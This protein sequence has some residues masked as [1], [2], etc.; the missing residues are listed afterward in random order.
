M[1]VCMCVRAEVLFCFRSRHTHARKITSGR[2]PSSYFRAYVLNYAHMLVGCWQGTPPAHSKPISTLQFK[3]HP[4]PLFSRHFRVFASA[5]IHASAVHSPHILRTHTHGRFKAHFHVQHPHVSS[6]TLTRTDV[7]FASRIEKNAHILVGC[8]Q[9]TPPA[10]SKPIS[11][12]Q[13]RVA[14]VPVCSL[15]TFRC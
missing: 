4:S 7:Q 6:F 14:P 15:A 3:S 11:T 12:L 13:V 2:T 5:C 9:G 1:C 8:W 10:H